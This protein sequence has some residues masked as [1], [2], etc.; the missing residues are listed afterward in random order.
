[1]LQITVPE[2][3][4]FIE[5]TSEFIKSPKTTLTLEHSLVS[6]SKWESNWEKPFLKNSKSLT[7]EELIDYIRCMTITPK[8]VHPLVYTT[9]ASNMSLLKQI[10]DYINKSMTATWFSEEDTKK[11]GPTKPVTSEVIYGWMVAM[12]IPPEYE[13]WHLNRLMTLIRVI[14]AENAPP[15]KK[16]RREMLS[17]R[18]ALNEARKKS[19]K[20]RG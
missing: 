20:T 3:E 18:K 19:L 5:D 14:D 6:L 11:S 1:M 4:W 10:S 15:K 8:N 7:S 9:L 13:K 17:S 2:K 12:R 16:S